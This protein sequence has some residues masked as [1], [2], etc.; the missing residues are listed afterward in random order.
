MRTTDARQIV[1]RRRFARQVNGD[2]WNQMHTNT[3]L[4]AWGSRDTNAK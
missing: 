3:A 4:V 2:A 1:I